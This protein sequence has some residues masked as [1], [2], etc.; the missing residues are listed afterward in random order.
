[1]NKFGLPEEVFRL[2]ADDTHRFESEEHRVQGG[3]ADLTLVRDR[4]LCRTVVRKRPRTDV[5]VSWNP[6][7]FMLEAQV[8]AQLD[9]PAVVPL[10][11]FGYDREGLYYLMPEVAGDHLGYV[12]TRLLEGDPAVTRT[13]THARRLQVFRTVCGAV[14]HA[15]ERGVVHRDIK[16]DQVLL[17]RHSEVLLTDWGLATRTGETPDHPAR[18]QPPGGGSG[19]ST[20]ITH[21][22]VVGD[23][24]YQ[25][26]ERLTGE[27][28]TADPTQ[29]VY[30]LG[31]LL[32]HLLTLRPPVGVPRDGETAAQ[33]L[34]RLRQ[35]IGNLPTPSSVSW[36]GFADPAWDALCMACLAVEPSD[37]PVDAGEL[38]H[39][40]EATLWKM[41]EAERRRTA[42]REALDRARATMA[43][44]QRLRSELAEIR[45]RRAE[46]V[47]EVPSHAPREQ[48]RQLWAVEDQEQESMLAAAREFAEAERLCE[49]ALSH[50]PAWTEARGVLADLYLERLMEADARNDEVGRAYAL[51]RLR[52]IDDGTRLDRLNQPAALVVETPVAEAMVRTSSLVERDRQLVPEDWRQHPLGRV[53]V[54]AGRIAV[55]VHAAGR[56]TARYALRLQPGSEVR[57]SPRLPSAGSILPGFTYVPAGPVVI[58]GD[59]GLDSGGA[60]RRVDMPDFAI[61]VYPVTM[62]EYRLFLDDLDEQESEA[63]VPQDSADGRPILV[64]ADGRWTVPPEDPHGHP[65]HGEFPV[66]SIRAE[67]AE[68]YCRWRSE[69]EARR[70]RLPTRDEWDYA[71]RSGDGR[72]YPWG[73]CNEPGFCW[74]RDAQEHKVLPTRVG[75]KETDVAPCG[76]RDLAGGVGDWLADDFDSTGRL[77]HMGGGSW[78]ASGSFLR[79]SRRFGFRVD[80]RSAGIGFRVLLELD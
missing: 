4:L 78:F 1:M 56:A 25:P 55:E 12:L 33:Y 50:D 67:D 65:L 49:L 24:R 59:P 61:G 30:S 60:S 5:Q 19:Q 69:R 29:D 80:E 3:S 32:F 22:C 79:L 28:L 6:L 15:H 23:P 13:Y 62:D 63:R 17:G 38:F 40:V 2:L 75:A 34:A 51:E 45:R 53:V 77:R 20:A 26:P 76:A 72:E 16:P 31:A 35:E 73:D 39:E 71:A 68:A 41:E 27:Q 48:R 11:Q 42:A 43:D 10:L 70:F 36:D 47:F 8:T 66:L 54:P 58:E 46:L 37:R 9:H 57:L 21:E 18:A 64:R 44:M 52:R 74:A 7:M 14:A